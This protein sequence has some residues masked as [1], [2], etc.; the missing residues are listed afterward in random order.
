MIEDELVKIWQSS[1][2]QERVKFEKSR[3]MIDVQSNLDTF[4]RKIKTRDWAEQIAALLGMPVFAYYAYHFPFVLT[5]IA[6]VLIIVWGIYVIYRLRSARKHKPTA[7]TETYLQYLYKSR[8]YLN[9]QKQMLDNILYWYIL[10]AMILMILFVLGPG[11]AGRLPKIMKTSAGIVGLS[12]VIYYLNKRA[13]KTQ[14][15][16]RL[17]KIDKLIKVMEEA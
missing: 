5:K 16:P 3:L 6:S 9:I 13:V 7:F 17:E 11:V 4:H 8:E 15:I 2:N 10:P 14:F 12:V 1:P